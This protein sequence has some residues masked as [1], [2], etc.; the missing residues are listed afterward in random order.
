M[1][2]VDLENFSRNFM[3]NVENICISL[4]H[5]EKAEVAILIYESLI[6]PSTDSD[7]A[8]SLI[9]EMLNCGVV[10]HYTALS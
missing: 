3:S 5:C 6:K 8:A 4:I 1:K 9:K 10:R 7:Y 2:L